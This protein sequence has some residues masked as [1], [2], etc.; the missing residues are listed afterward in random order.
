MADII[1]DEKSTGA[2]TVS[3]ADRN[4]VGVTPNWARWTLSTRGGEVI[5]ARESVAISPLGQ[6]VEIRLS[7]DDLQILPGEVGRAYAFRL[8][9]IEAEYNS[10]LGLNLPSKGQYEFLVKNLAYV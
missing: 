10:D 2:I 4:G 1:F 8:L 5:A 3:F 7:G 9:T 6:S